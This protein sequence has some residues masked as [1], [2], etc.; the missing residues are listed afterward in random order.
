[1]TM[2]SD[3][4][5][6]AAVGDR[7]TGGPRPSVRLAGAEWHRAPKVPGSTVAMFIDGSVPGADLYGGVN[8]LAPGAVIPA[9]W[10]SVGE[11]QFILSGTGVTVDRDGVTSPIGPHSVIFAPAGPDGVH[12]FTNTGLVPLSILFL[13]PSPGGA[14]PDFN[15]VADEMP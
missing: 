10:H 8:V 9:H 15:L 7:V 5:D 1:M 12:G 11:L 4:R 6:D 3:E 14:A 13:Y 2:R